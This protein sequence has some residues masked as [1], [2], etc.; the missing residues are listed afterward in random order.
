[1]TFVVIDTNV[2]IG[3]LLNQDDINRKVL[4]Y[5][6]QGGL[7]PLMSDGMYFEYE[8]MMGRS[9]LFKDCNFI[10]G[11]RTILFNDFCSICHWIDVYYRWRPHFKDE[12]ES[13]MI[14]LAIGGGADLILTWNKKDLVIDDS[15]VKELLIL[16][17]D[18]FLELEKD[19]QEA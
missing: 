1:M 16:T 14:E 17:P 15:I 10:E 6:F 18:E 13:H 7:R 19:K 8:T 3:A 2:F 4:D 5:C 11:E 9:Y 12:V